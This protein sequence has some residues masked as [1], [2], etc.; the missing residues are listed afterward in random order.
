MTLRKIYLPLLVLAL[1][2]LACNIQSAANTPTTLP[3]ALATDT[4]NP[5]TAAIPSATPT[6]MPPP[7][8]PTNTTAAI[9]STPGGLT[10]E[11]LKNATYHVP[12]YD[13]TV[14]LV[15]G[16]Y[17]NGS[18]TDPYSV[19]MLDKVAF[20][21]LNGDGK[22]DAAVILAENGGGSGIFESVIA[23][24]DQSGNPHQQSQAGL[25][26]RFLINSIDISSGVIHL[27]MVVQGPNDPMCC[28]TRPQKQNYW[29]ID[30]RLWLMR[31]TSTLG[32]TEHIVQVDSPGIW[33]TV[34]NPFT[35]H[36]SVNVLPFE[37]TLAYRIYLTDGTKV[38]ESSLTVTPTTGTAGTFT[39]DFNLSAAGISDWVIL[40]FVDISA[41]DGSIIALG[42]V[43]LKAH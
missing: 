17:S 1:V 16:S 24:L 21:D 31:Q 8:T 15:N 20:G 39:H 19:Q 25:G 34:S 36:G 26:D 22:A 33:A 23:V 12:A 28:P 35:V 32:G 9:V 14:T 37:N 4:P 7:P 2:S 3:P 18:A 42:S 5:P 38:N 30:N 11:M 41:A 40:Q 10:L 27:D 13:R 6:E 43:I 29:L